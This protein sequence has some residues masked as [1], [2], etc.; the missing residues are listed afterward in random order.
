MWLWTP[1]GDQF[2]G[3]DDVS[4]VYLAIAV[5]ATAATVGTAATPASRIGR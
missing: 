4:V 1:G 3:Y 5:F 2:F